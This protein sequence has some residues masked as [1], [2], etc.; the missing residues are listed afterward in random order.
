MAVTPT[1]DTPFNRDNW[2]H[3]DNGYKI[4]SNINKVKAR[5]IV[6]GLLSE[7]LTF[8]T[9]LKDHRNSFVGIVQ[10][11]D[12]PCIIKVP[13]GRNKRLWER[14]LTL[15]RPS[16]AYRC[17]FSM[18]KLRS[19]GLRCPEP[20]LAAQRRR[21]GVVVDSFFIYE[22]QEGEA[23]SSADLNLISKEMIKLHESGYIRSDPKPVNFIKNN[24]EIY[25][26][27]FRLKKPIVFP[28]LRIMINALGS[29]GGNI[30]A[31][32]A[33]YPHHPPVLV[34]S[35]HLFLKS[36]KAFKAGRKNL[37]KL[38]V[39]MWVWAQ[40]FTGT[41]IQPYLHHPLCQGVMVGDG[42]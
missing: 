18:M 17:Y 39:G 25:F 26:I 40:Y 7:N 13:L 20:I 2:E 32:V 5:E 38:L 34:G 41:V 15:F 14:F 11:E 3:P 42:V 16:D 31:T 22:L 30:H 8:P 23:A 27:D 36:M 21:F 33:Q 6:H 1:K 29:A 37:S 4:V 24:D 28:T 9:I 12:K 19:L 35:A 10:L